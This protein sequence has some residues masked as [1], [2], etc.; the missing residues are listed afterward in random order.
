M[1]PHLLQIIRGNYERVLDLFPG[2]VPSR[3][4]SHRVARPVPGTK[5]LLGTSGGGE[6]AAG[7]WLGDS[8]ELARV[9]DDGVRLSR[10]PVVGH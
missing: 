2:H 10:L 6:L 7:L 1:K 8:E 4:I 3:R 9:H 5:G